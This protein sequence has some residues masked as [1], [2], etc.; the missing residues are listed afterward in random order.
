[1]VRF[2]AD[3]VKE[4]VVYVIQPEWLHECDV[5]VLAQ[6]G[7]VRTSM[8]VPLIR[9]AIRER[10]HEATTEVMS[11]SIVIV[12]PIYTEH[13]PHWGAVVQ[14][15]AVLMHALE[16][17]PKEYNN[18]P[19][20]SSDKTYRPLWGPLSA[21]TAVNMYG[22]GIDLCK[23]PSPGWEARVAATKKTWLALFNALEPKSGPYV[24]MTERIASE[25]KKP[26]PIVH[27]PRPKL[28]EPPKPVIPF[29]APAPTFVA[30]TGPLKPYIPPAV[31]TQPV[32]PAMPHDIVDLTRPY[33]RDSHVIDLTMS[34]D[35]E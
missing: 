23:T 35:E 15:A 20:Y 26:K 32:A 16:P 2:I 24:P 34:S 9:L 6:S 30:P 33:P 28:P 1:M 18:D 29:V 7:E 19:D 10:K 13:A 3:K 14:S 12:S 21:E 25:A 22:N 17:M 31:P 4:L 5:V 8:E 27:V 11:T